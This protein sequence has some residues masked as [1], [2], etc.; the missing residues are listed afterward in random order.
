M[1]YATYMK[2]ILANTTDFENSM[3]KNKGT[4][5]GGSCFHKDS[6]DL[7]KIG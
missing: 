7:T 2:K 5:I 3:H 4:W 6:N 1:K